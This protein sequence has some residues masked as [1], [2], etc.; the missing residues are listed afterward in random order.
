MSSLT[1]APEYAHSHGSQRLAACIS[2]LIRWDAVAAVATKIG[3][4]LAAILDNLESRRIAV[5]L[6]GVRARTNFGDEHEKAFAVMFAGLARKY[7]VLFFPAINE[8]V[9]DDAQLKAVDGLHPNAAGDK[10]IVAQILPIVETLID[11]ARPRDRD[12]TP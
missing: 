6:C 12:P 8:A 1:R 2:T 4:A 10:A 3:A 5:L 11:R 9:I 7:N